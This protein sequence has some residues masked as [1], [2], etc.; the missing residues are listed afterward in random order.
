[1]ESINYSSD[2]IIN[3]ELNAINEQRNEARLT[4]AK[5]TTSK[6]RKGWELT[7]A[8]LTLAAIW[9]VIAVLN[10]YHLIKEF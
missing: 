6:G 1:M 3:R 2:S 8:L 4:A 5:V 10:H 9:G 7:A